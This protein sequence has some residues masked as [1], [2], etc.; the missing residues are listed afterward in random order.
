MAKAYGLKKL[1]A[2]SAGNAASALAAYAAA[3]GLEAAHF[4][5]PRRAHG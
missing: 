3:A 1:A 4:H 2:P 5:A